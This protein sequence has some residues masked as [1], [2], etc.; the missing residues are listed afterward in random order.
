ME[1]EQ[2]RW[3]RT[4]PD[5]VLCRA[6]KNHGVWKSSKRGS[7]QGIQRSSSSSPLE[8]TWQ[9]LLPP[10]TMGQP[11]VGVDERTEK[12]PPLQN[13]TK[14]PRAGRKGP[15]SSRPTHNKH[16]KDSTSILRSEEIY[17]HI[18]WA[19]WA[20]CQHPMVQ[21][22]NMKHNDTTEPFTQVLWTRGAFVTI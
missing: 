12:W 20:G 7:R 2:K 21:K 15:L 16:E 19:S 14:C 3:P 11:K 18:G 10:G 1:L 4:S 6:N 22:T 17:T 13:S 8:V 9:L 5:V